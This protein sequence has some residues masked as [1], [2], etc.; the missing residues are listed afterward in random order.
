MKK[1][2]FPYGYA[3][4]KEPKKRNLGEL[5][6]NRKTGSPKK[7]DQDIDKYTG[8]LKEDYHSRIFWKT[9]NLLASVESPSIFPKNRL[10]ASA[11]LDPVQ[12]ERFRKVRNKRTSYEMSDPHII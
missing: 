10:Y 6:P 5:E 7:A 11:L 9:R 3:L 8:D 1:K 4:A 2:S 12:R